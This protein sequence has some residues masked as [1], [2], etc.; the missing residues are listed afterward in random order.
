MSK[1]VVQTRRRF[2]RETAEHE[3]TVLHDDGLYRHLRFQKP[4][5]SLYWFDLLTWPGRLVIAG[6]CG[7]YMFS[8]IRDMFEFFESDHGGIN[9]DYWAEKLQAPAPQAAYRYSPEVFRTRVLEWFADASDD[10]EAEEAESL[11]AALNEQVLD[12]AD[13][14]LQVEGEAR[15]RL[16]YFEHDGRHIADSWEW[17]LREFDWQFLW[18][19]HAIVWGIAQYRH[20]HVSR[21]AA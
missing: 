13:G 17:R 9:P 10:L 3:M 5:T 12:D 2:E 14:L 11:R 6:D 8:R 16:S 1:Q 20:L 18:C 7:D 15:R 19:C 4:G 21:R